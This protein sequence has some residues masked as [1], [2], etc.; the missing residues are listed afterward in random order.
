ME[1]GDLV[2]CV[3]CFKG[4]SNL[5]AVGCEEGKFA[6]YDVEKQA[7]IF[8]Y[9]RDDAVIVS[10]VADDNIVYSATE[11]TIFKHDIRENGSGN[12]IFT[13]P[14]EISDFSVNDNLLAVATMSND[15]I[16]TDKRVLKK[17]KSSPILPP[18]CNS[19]C[20]KNKDKIIAGYIDLSVGEWTLSSRKFNGYKLNNPGQQVNPAVVHCVACSGNT[21]AAATQNGLSIFVD[22]KIIASGQFEHDGAVHCVTF[23][24]CFPGKV[25]VSGGAD[26]SLMVLDVDNKKVIDVI[27]NEEEKIQMISA[28]AK[29]IAVADTSDAG[30]IGIF[31]PDDFGK[32]DEEEK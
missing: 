7:S 4:T 21:T 28:N 26:G 31:T 18:V 19:L 6:V 3:E 17:Q 29:F 23:A 14:S 27:G 12:L 5:I 24:P 20:F 1:V 13:A 15:I 32:N 22:G 30:S 11:T 8:E 16:L 25:T 9:Q 10:R 2:D